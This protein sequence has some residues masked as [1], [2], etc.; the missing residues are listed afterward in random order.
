MQYVIV[1][2]VCLVYVL[3]RNGAIVVCVLSSVQKDLMYMKCTDDSSQ[4]ADMPVIVV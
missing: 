2:A 1:E 4:L 3:F